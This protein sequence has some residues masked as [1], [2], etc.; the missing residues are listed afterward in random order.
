MNIQASSLVANEVIVGKVL[1]PYIAREQLLGAILSFE[2]KSETALLHI[3]QVAGD[4]TER[5]LNLKIGEEVRV[6]ITI[7]IENGVRKVRASEKDLDT[8]QEIADKLNALPDSS[9][10]A[11]SVV[12]V[13]PYGI[14]VS[15]DDT[16]KN[17]KGLVHNK[18]MYSGSDMSLK[19]FGEL[20]PGKEVFVRIL[21]A[22]LDDSGTLRID[23]AF[24]TKPV[25]TSAAKSASSVL[26]ILLASNR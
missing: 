15:L 21:G 16:F 23:L 17:R 3:K 14:F 6:K 9:V 4:P 8:D 11:A 7:A 10:L 2:D 18:N 26:P 5:L 22:R 24:A 1:R 12:N 20:V 25:E 13:A 19:S